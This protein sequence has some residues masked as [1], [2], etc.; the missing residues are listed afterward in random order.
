MINLNESSQ[1][2]V[3]IHNFEN[4]KTFFQDSTKI[5]KDLHV[6]ELRHIFIT[7]SIYIVCYL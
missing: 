7:R 1:S 3:L 5:K 6:P 2:C 4:F